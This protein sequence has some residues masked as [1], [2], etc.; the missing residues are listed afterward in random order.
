M[1]G[2]LTALYLTVNRH[3]WG[4][5]HPLP[6]SWIDRVTPFLPY[7]LPLYLCHI[8]Q[9]TLAYIWIRKP[10]NVS[11][12]IYSYTALQLAS[13][14]IFLIFPT[15]FPR[16]N[17]PI[18]SGLPHELE[19]LWAW[20][21]T[22]DSPTN[23]FPSLHVS[24]DFLSAF[25]FLDEES[26]TKFWF[27]FIWAVLISI[28]TLTTKQHYFADIVG[29]FAFSAFFFWLFHRKASYYSAKLPNLLQF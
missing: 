24:S 9:L 25:V 16:E 20:L 10:D 14:A 19:A 1:Y 12:F 18:P 28:S 13:C 29:G 11:K 4:I 17:Y 22:T 26:P 8:L 27:L 15:I 21:R 6:L 5:A 7:T 23:C 2:P 3:T